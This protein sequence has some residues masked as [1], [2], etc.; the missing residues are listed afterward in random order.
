MATTKAGRRRA[1]G[2]TSIQ[3]DALNPAA[4]LRLWDKC[5]PA[6][7]P[8]RARTILRASYP[9]VRTE[10][11]DA[12][13]IGAWNSALLR[14]RAAQFGT[15]LQVFDRC[16]HCEG[17]VEFGIETSEILAGSKPV[18]AEGSFSTGDWSVRFR[19]LTG[20]DWVQSY[21]PE[22]TETIVAA[23]RLLGRAIV[24]VRRGE[25]D[26]VAEDM[27]DAAWEALAEALLQ[28]DSASEIVFHLRCPSCGAQWESPLEPAEFVWREINA[29]CRR[30]LRHIHVLASTYGWSE[31][32]ILRLSQERRT[33]YLHL[34]E[35]TGGPS[36]T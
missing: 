14:F 31:S 3:P 29:A 35:E 2:A 13:A 16:P 7:L 10:E 1:E 18:L 12:M 4:L 22:G 30:L 28:A 27:P 20:G 17:N 26:A 21:K 33:S 32:E 6:G 24:Q 34:I 23:K 9:G 15:Q 8:Q 5:A 19:L 11:L 25:N 36:G